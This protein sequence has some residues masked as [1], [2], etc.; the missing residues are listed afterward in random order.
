MFGQL[1]IRGVKFKHEMLTRISCLISGQFMASGH[2]CL[3]AQI[4]LTWLSSMDLRFQ[5]FYSDL[6][7]GFTWKQQRVDTSVVVGISC[8]CFSFYCCW[9]LSFFLAMCTV[10]CNWWLPWLSVLFL[11]ITDDISLWLMTKTAFSQ[12]N[13]F[14][15]ENEKLTI[16]SFIDHNYSSFVLIAPFGCAV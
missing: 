13:C 2:P 15:L 3:L 5:S 9:K 14:F 6:S 7:P 1:G 11:I 8:F 10:F 4:S 12:S 16:L